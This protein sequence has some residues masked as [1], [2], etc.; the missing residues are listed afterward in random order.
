MKKP[1]PNPAMNF[2]CSVE[3]IAEQ[4]VN[5]LIESRR[6]YGDSWRQEGGFSAWF[7]IK[8]KID[9]LVQLMKRDPEPVFLG[10][11]QED[12]TDVTT[13]DRY[14]IFS[15]IVADVA[16]GGEKVLDAVRDLRRYLT[17]TEAYMVQQGYDLPQSRDNLLYDKRHEQELAKVAEAIENDPPFKLTEATENDPPFKLTEH[18]R[19]VMGLEQRPQKMMSVD[20]IFRLVQQQHQE[21]RGD[22]GPRGFDATLDLPYSGPNVFTSPDKYRG[23]SY[24]QSSREAKRLL[25]EATKLSHWADLPE[26]LTALRQNMRIPARG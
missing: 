4:D 24:E 20:H 13:R 12:G 22:T 26:K 23:M 21:R 5:A 18:E 10:Y 14:D 2:D 25:E 3:E 7:N 9:R 16:E 6:H 19:V 11:E 8:R 1:K 15:H 17:L